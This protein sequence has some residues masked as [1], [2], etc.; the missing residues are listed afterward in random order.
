[1]TNSRQAVA[2]LFNLIK[3]SNSYTVIRIFWAG[4]SVNFEKKIKNYLGVLN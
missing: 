1:M 4:K 2:N 3:R